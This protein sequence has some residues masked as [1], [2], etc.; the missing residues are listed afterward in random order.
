MQQVTFI[1]VGLF[2][3]AR[4]KNSNSSESSV[5]GVGAGQVSTTIGV[6]VGQAPPERE[7]ILYSRI[8]LLETKVNVN[9]H[10]KIG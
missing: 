4:S 7:V 5:G 8:C 9:A 10:S 2:V 1:E 6:G 3:A